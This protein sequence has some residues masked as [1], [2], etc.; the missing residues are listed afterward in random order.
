EGAL[1][2][3]AGVSHDEV[4]MVGDSLTSDIEG[5]VRYGLP[6]CWYNPEGRMNPSGPSPTHEIRDLAE[7]PGLV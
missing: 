6:T 5:G 7:L 3:F 4:L 2:P 1:A